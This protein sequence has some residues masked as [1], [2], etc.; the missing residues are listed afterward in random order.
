M[1]SRAFIDKCM[2]NNDSVLLS[3]PAV[4]YI[5][6]LVVLGYSEYFMGQIFV[7]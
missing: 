7:P 1:H 2:M 6:S 4:H 3:S 5:V